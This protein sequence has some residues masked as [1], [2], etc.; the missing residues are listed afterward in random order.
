MSTE[1]ILGLDIGPRQI[2]AVKITCGRKVRIDALETMDIRKYGGLE[3]AL[4]QIRERNLDCGICVTSVHPGRLSLR[5][6]SMPFRDERKIRQTIAFELESV[7]P[8]PIED[9]VVDFTVTA[10]GDPPELPAQ[11]LAAVAPA[12]I[13]R[14]RVRLL[15]NFV[16]EV[17]V[18][19][20]DAFPLAA[21]LAKSGLTGCALLVDIGAEKSAGFLLDGG[22]VLNIRS[23]DFGG[24]TLTGIIAKAAG[25]SPADAEEAKISGGYAAAKNM[26][27]KACREFA[28]EL[29]ATLEMLRRSGQ[30]A[31]PA[32]IL[33]TGGGALFPEMRESFEKVFGIGAESADLTRI[34][35]FE[36]ASGLP[37]WGLQFNNALALALRGM[38][39][40]PG[41]NFRRGAFALEKHALKLK[42]DLR[43]AALMVVISVCAL[44]IGQGLG[45][46]LDYIKL[47]RLK[48]TINAVFQASCPDVTK[49][50]DPVQQLKTKIA[51]SRKVSVGSAG[52]PFL[53][54]LREISATVP[55]STGFLITSLAYDGERIDIKAETT[56][57]DS[58]AEVKRSLAGSRHFSNVALGSANMMKQGG[59][60]EISIRMDVRK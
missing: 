7:I 51:D 44:I 36:I 48:S 23:F 32:K 31:D 53:E 25:L 28:E 1:C 5:N 18:I 54:L 16:P 21:K 19:D 4:G 11:V 3:S 10:D 38:K 40:S 37:A 12:A 20:V 9:A 29:K 47:N 8:Y 50:V 13:I 57:F 15:E 35:D 59:K 56:S 14:D 17:S 52:T 49:I 43:W 26:A 41:M 24:D 6:I 22:R 34:E 45:Y 42:R 58:A 60:V 2:K 39:K 33:F 55:Q 46:Y 27:D 30:A